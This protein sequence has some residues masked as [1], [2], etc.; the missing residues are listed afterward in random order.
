MVLNIP[1]TSFGPTVFGGR[2]SD[3]EVSP[4]NPNH[5]YVGYAS[6]GLWETE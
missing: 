3:I 5:F 6:G 2:V 1:F 4:M